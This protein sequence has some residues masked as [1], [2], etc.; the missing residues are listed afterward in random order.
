M[1]R[2][3][4]PL[5]WSLVTWVLSLWAGRTEADVNC[6]C[7]YN[8]SPVAGIRGWVE[9][10]IKDRTPPFNCADLDALPDSNGGATCGYSSGSCGYSGFTYVSRKGCTAGGLTIGRPVAGASAGFPITDINLGGC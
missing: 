8:W 7:Y 3:S 5:F 6:L 4:K 1:K 10:R 2:N 9:V